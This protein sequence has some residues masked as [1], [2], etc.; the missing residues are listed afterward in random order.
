MI[1]ALAYD[2]DNQSPKGYANIE[3]Q[4][5]VLHIPCVQSSLVLGR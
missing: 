2:Q 3:R 5:H 4:T 1:D